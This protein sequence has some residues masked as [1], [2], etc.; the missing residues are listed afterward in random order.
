MLRQRSGSFVT[1]T[2]TGGGRGCGAPTHAR[3]KLHAAVFTRDVFLCNTAPCR[4]RF[5]RY[6]RPI[7]NTDD[8]PSRLALLLHSACFDYCLINRLKRNI[9]LEIVTAADMKIVSRWRSATFWVASVARY[10]ALLLQYITRFQCVLPATDCTMLNNMLQ[11]R[12]RE[13]RPLR[14]RYVRRRQLRYD[15]LRVPVALRR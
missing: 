12:H 4:S 9:L 10:S 13:R 11:P 2:T 1:A 7:I 15:G 14:R 3:V 6:Y 8:L 5:V